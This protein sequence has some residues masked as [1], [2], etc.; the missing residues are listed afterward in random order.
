MAFNIVKS[1]REIRR[2]SLLDTVQGIGF[3]RPIEGHP[4]VCVL[5]WRNLRDDGPKGEVQVDAYCL[6]TCRH[7]SVP[8]WGISHWALSNN[9]EELSWP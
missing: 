7:W 9:D 6:G 8:T 1:I 2:A 3:F 4:L 5:H